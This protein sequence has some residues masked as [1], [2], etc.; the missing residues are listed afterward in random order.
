MKTF[1]ANEK[2]VFQNCKK[3]QFMYLLIQSDLY[4]IQDIHWVSS[5][6]DWEL[7]PRLWH[8]C[9][10]YRNVIILY[11]TF[12]LLYGGHGYVS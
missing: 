8:Y 2:S 7:N 6:I 5:C 11:I 12:P 4:C 1:L 3:Y 9:L 10:G